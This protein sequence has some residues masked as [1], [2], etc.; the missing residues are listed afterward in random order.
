MAAEALKSGDVLDIRLE[1]TWSGV[2]DRRAGNSWLDTFAVYSVSDGADH[3]AFRYVQCSQPAKDGCATFATSYQFGEAHLLLF[4]IFSVNRVSREPESIGRVVCTPLDMVVY[5][6]LPYTRTLVDRQGKKLPGTLTVTPRPENRPA[7]FVLLELSARQLPQKKLFRSTDAMLELCSQDG[8]VMFATE[9][10]SG[11]R[12][13]RWMPLAINAERFP[14]GLLALRCYDVGLTGDRTFVGQATAVLDELETGTSLELDAP[15]GVSAALEPR[16]SDEKPV[17]CV[18]RC[19]QFPWTF[20]DY[21]HGDFDM[22]FAFVIDLSSSNGDLSAGSDSRR[23]Y[24]STISAFDDVIQQFDE[25][26]LL[27]ALG[28][29]ARAPTGLMSQPLVFLA[30]NGEPRVQGTR[31]VLEAY[32]HSLE[33]LLP[34]EPSELAPALTYVSQLARPSRYYVALVLTDGRLDY[35][36][37]T[38]DCLAKAAGSALSVVLLVLGEE[39]CSNGL[40]RDVL[41]RRRPGLRDCVHMLEVAPYRDRMHELPRDALAPVPGQ[42]MQYLS[43]NGVEPALGL[44]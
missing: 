35:G 26:Q 29:G 4:E 6:D 18:E 36:L 12:S 1:L 2:R 22:H 24:E 39:G 13:P 27:P 19:R 33:K 5:M 31:G 23:L 30:A 8:S 3:S 11:S 14:G 32:A 15:N 10:V 7:G 37:S 34:A 42:I 25:E 41:S 38:L 17:V 20:I 28:F 9:V 43:L 21:L 40:R 44:Q 16:S